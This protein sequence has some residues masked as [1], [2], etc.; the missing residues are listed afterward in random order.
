M[1]IT[2]YLI[3]S[4]VAV[5][6]LA[7]MSAFAQA[8]P[9]EAANSEEIVVTAR[10][11]DEK[12]KDVPASV[13]VI[14][15]GAIANT[16]ARV[17]ADYVQL[18]PGV[19]IVTG[20]VEAGDTQIAIRG[21][22]GARDGENNVALVVD[23]VLKS[24]TA[25]LAQDQ[26]A[27]KQI[28]ILK[29]P[30]G[31]YYGRSAVAGAIVIATKKP[32]DK[33]EVSGRLSGANNNTFSGAAVI[34]G[35]LGSNVG[36]VLNGEYA[37]TDGFYRDV[38]QTSALYGTTYPKQ[39]PGIGAS[40]DDNERFNINGR[41]LFTPSSDTEIDIKARYSKL[42]GAAIGFNAIFQLPGLAA[43]FNAPVF[44]IDANDH[45]FVFARNIN[46]ENNQRS[47]EASIRLAQTL[48]DTIKLTGYVSYSDTKNDFFADGTS[49]TFGFF[50]KEPNCMA[51]AAALKGFPVQAPF[52]VDLGNPGV[53]LNPY[54]PVTC[55]GSQ[56]QQRDQKD[57]SAE[58]RIAGEAGSAINW[59]LGG[60]YLNIDRFNCN[61][62]GVDTG[63]GVIRQCYTTDARNPTEALAEDSFK[64]NVYALFGSLE[65]KPT[66]KLKI[67]AAGRFDIEKRSTENGIPTGRRTRWVGNVLTGNPNGTE[68]TPANY[69]L[70]PGL[71]PAYNPSGVLLPR[72]QTYKHFQ[73][74]ISVSYAATDDISVF[75][76]WGVGF[77]TGG[78]NNAGSAAIVNGFFNAGIGAGLTIFDDYKKEISSSF[79][80][81]VKGNI[82]PGVNFELAGYYTNVRNSQFFE[83]FVGPFGL[84]RV[85]SNID[86]VTFKGIEGSFNARVYKGFSVFGSANYT[87]SEI[88]KNSARPYT[89]GNDAPATSKYTINVGGQFDGP[90]TDSLGL[91]LRADYRVT[92]PTSFHTVQNNNVPTIFGLGANYTNSQRDAYGILNLRGGLK[93]DHWSLV[94]FANNVTKKRYL[95]EV[96]VAPEF[97]GAFVAP[98][99]LRTIGVEGTFKF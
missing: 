22:N 1:R 38:F 28:E 95:A 97:G 86:K 66:D 84:L 77:K 33:L 72:K 53:F 10:R 64:T 9:Q 26:G 82:A 75:A 8:A 46:P 81:G 24:N 42:K 19:T 45:Q 76:N 71:D 43:A 44:N 78:F 31:A 29:G 80:A 85:V 35:P 99:A 14:T 4:S 91:L 47:V 94:A 69:Y 63:Q 49:G 70:N 73:P 52:G 30:Q 39:A 96:I 18:T 13:T 92:G 7:P 65:Y 87:D 37:T 3:L 40:V 25:L 54:S 62:L 57:I 17:A 41:L 51:S 67:S 56:Y 36:F 34:S 5:S 50:N 48:T 27:L 2:K 74:K 59:S 15:A 55:D 89:V 83:F 93:G 68:E 20:V 61:N 90:L 23:G 16:G 21:I 6:A 11:E 88:K 32:G 58:L 98:G 79:E 60:Y 12:L